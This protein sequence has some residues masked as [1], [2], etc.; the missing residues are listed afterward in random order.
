MALHIDMRVRR[1]APFPDLQRGAL[2]QAVA[3]FA[4]ENPPKGTGRRIAMLK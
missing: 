2:Q 1:V 4:P 3:D